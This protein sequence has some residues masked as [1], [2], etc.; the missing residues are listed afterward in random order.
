MRLSGLAKMLACTNRRGAP[1][2][3][4]RRASHTR[5]LKMFPLLAEAQLKP[6]QTGKDVE[7]HLAFH[8]ER[9]QGD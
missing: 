5:N 4:E 6:G 9:L 3:E 8:A 2:S 1:L 7:A